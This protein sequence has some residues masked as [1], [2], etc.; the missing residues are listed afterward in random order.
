MLFGA[1]FYFSKP[2]SSSKLDHDVYS[3][4]ATVAEASCAKVRDH[5]LPHDRL[6]LQ[7]GVLFGS[8]WDYKVSEVSRWKLS[9][10]WPF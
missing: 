10:D 2:V 9:M 7:D 8:N 6:Q 4:L 1:R 5:V 3:R